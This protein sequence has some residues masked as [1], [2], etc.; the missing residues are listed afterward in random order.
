MHRGNTNLSID[1]G[2]KA[3]KSIKSN[4]V[5]TGSGISYSF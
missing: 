4:I 2:G 3:F 1:G 5:Y